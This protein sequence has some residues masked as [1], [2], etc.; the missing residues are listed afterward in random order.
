MNVD[1]AQ[2][3]AMLGQ[4]FNFNNL[5]NEKFLNIQE[6]VEALLNQK[7]GIDGVDYFQFVSI[8]F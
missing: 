3:D 5:G 4:Q 7:S 2:L 6:K 1:P 8:F